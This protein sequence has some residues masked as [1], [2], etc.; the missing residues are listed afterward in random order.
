MAHLNDLPNNNIADSRL[1][2]PAA[3][4]S[5]EEQTSLSF[6]GPIKPDE[7][8]SAIA[9][10]E[11]NPMTHQPFRVEKVGEIVHVTS[12]DLDGSA[13]QLPLAPPLR[14]SAPVMRQPHAPHVGA[15][16]CRQLSLGLSCSG[17][18]LCLHLSPAVFF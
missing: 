9:R 2:I 8:N 15:L 12:C 4:P 16:G 10:G 3:L 1:F 11:I 6:L 5:A 18:H 7:I 13:S 14:R 17:V